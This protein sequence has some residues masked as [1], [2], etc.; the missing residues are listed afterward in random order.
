MNYRVPLTASN[1]RQ[2][3]HSTGIENVLLEIAAQQRSGNKLLGLVAVLL[4][5]LLVWVVVAA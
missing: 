1:V 2:P 3:H 4:F 5:G